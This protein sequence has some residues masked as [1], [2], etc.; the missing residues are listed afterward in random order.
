MF[1]ELSLRT[2]VNCCAVIP[3]F[4]HTILTVCRRLYSKCRRETGPVSAVLVN[5]CLDVYRRYCF[6]GLFCDHC[7]SCRW[8]THIP[9][10][11]QLPVSYATSYRMCKEGYT[12]QRSSHNANNRDLR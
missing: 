10:Y 6:G 9:I 4:M 1:L 3:V 11:I 5:P 12:V 8:D 7:L 2:V